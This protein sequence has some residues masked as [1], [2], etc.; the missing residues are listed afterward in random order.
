MSETVYVPPAWTGV[1]LNPD[2]SHPLQATGFDVKSRKQYV[3]SSAH[4]EAAKSSKFERVRQLLIEQEDIRSQIEADLNDYRVKGKDRE[5]ALASYLVFLTGIRPGSNAETL[6][7]KRA[8][9]CTTLQL[10]HVKPCARGVRLKFTGKKG[11]QQNVLVTNPYLVEHFLARKAATT[12][13]TAP[14]F[15]CSASKLNGYIATLGSGSYTAKDFRTLRGTSLALEILGSR[16]RFPRKQADRKRLLNAAL[17]RVAKQ[18]GNTRAVS[19]S[20]YVDPEILASVLEG[21]QVVF[22]EE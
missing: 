1:W 12:S 14:L 21:R 17:D 20:A 8:Y 15:C 3:Y 18:L 9:G 4:E 22:G 2:P 6:A 13:Y 5:A 10:R 11:V 19:R 16:R 7:D